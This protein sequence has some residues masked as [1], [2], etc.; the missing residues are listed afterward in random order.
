[1][2]RNLCKAFSK[3]QVKEILYNKFLSSL[4]CRALHPAGGSTL[5]QNNPKLHNICE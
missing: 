2:L 3:V 1:M 4:F 5:L